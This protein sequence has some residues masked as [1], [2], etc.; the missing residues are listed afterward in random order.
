MTAPTEYRYPAGNVLY[1]RLNRSFACIVRGE[2]CW[3]FDSQGKRYLDA[4]GGALVNSIGHGVP[5]IAR[6]IGD[7]AGKIAYVN[8]TA[9]TSAPVERLAEELAALSAP[10][11][12]KTLFMCS[13][14]DAVEGALKLARQYWVDSGKAEK[15]KIIA[16]HPAYHGSSLLALS[17]SGRQHY[18]ALFKDWLVDVRT[19]PAPYA[20]RCDCRGEAADCPSC[21][22]SV[23]EEAIREEGP[24]RVAAFIAEPIGGS[25]TGATV[26]RPEYF[27]RIREICDLHQV[28]LIAD[29]VMVGAGRTGTWSALEPYG[30]SPDFQ[31]F[32]KGLSGGYA[33]LS[34]L[35]TSSRIVDVFL[36][37][38][39]MP[40]HNQTFS[41]FAV[42][43]SAGLAVIRYLK[44]HDLIQRCARMGRLLHERLAA[45][46][47]HPN[48][49]DV[50]GRG[51]LAAVEFVADKESGRPFRREQRMVERF[52]E[53]ALAAGLV[54]WPSSG[55]VDGVNG[56]LVMIGPPFIINEEEIEE[57][58]GRFAIALEATL[59]N[60]E[61]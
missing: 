43:C 4:C 33:P 54:V 48:V 1:R 11:L 23:V 16:L 30:V 12:D 2:G 39:G 58:L 27:R 42:S 10:G 55:M 13:G 7:Q 25:S 24:H 52:T 44:E 40:L 15:H 5:E 37:Q 8:G 59:K 32:G 34:A 31:I 22:G 18:R 28:L 51:L 9:F 46:L 60:L 50:R 26:P 17:A 21:S 3:L 57:L 6:A 20:Y 14:A 61:H 45:L 56:D 41:Q 19:V 29:E 49:G 36:G 35:V 47:E 53:S 38:R